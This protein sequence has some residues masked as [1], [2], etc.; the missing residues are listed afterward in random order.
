MHAPFLEIFSSVQGEGLLVGERQVFLRFLGCN[1]DCAYCDTV[2]ARIESATCRV[3]RGAGSEQFD[4]V[5]NPLSVDEVVEA[6]AHLAKPQ[7]GLHH[8][9]ALTGGEPLLHTDF[10]LA[11]LPRLGDLGLG[12]YLETNGTLAEEAARVLPHLDVVCT[13]LKLPSATRQ[14]P[15]WGLHE[16]FLLALTACEDPSRLDFAKAV[17]GAETTAEEIDTACQLLLGISPDMPLVLQPVTP[18]QGGVEAP[19]PRQVLDLQARG[20]RHLRSVRVIPQTH[21]LG[22]YL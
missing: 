3:E 9:V 14:A 18:T 7:P 12:A 16:R 8:S 1:L 15:V 11:L 10:L 19:S 5:A 21:R 4:E 13:D 22:G 20:K 6:V 2:A 17:V